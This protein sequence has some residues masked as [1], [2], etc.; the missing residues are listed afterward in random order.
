MTN[1]RGVS[2]SSVISKVFESCLI[3]KCRKY[4]YSHDIQFGFKKHTDCANAVYTVQ[5][6]ANYC[7]ERESKVYMTALDAS[8]ALIVAQSDA[9]GQ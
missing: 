9:S 4:L 6:V 2:L 7:T 5:Q 8:K 3:D 1:Y